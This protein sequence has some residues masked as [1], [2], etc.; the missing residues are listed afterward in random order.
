MRNAIENWC[1]EKGKY[2][3][4][5]MYDFMTLCGLRVG[6]V[7][8]LRFQ[9]VVFEVDED[10]DECAYITVR[11]SKNDKY[12]EVYMPDSL[13]EDYKRFI[14]NLQR[15]KD[16]RRYIFEHH[17][18]PYGDTAIRTL[19]FRI[20]KERNLTH[21]SPHCLRH[22]FAI[23]KIYKGV[24]MNDLQSDMG[25]ASYTTTARYTLPSRENKR[26]SRNV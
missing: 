12:R 25:H 4:L 3:Q 20:C 18:K 16:A 15:R 26:K 14:S 13:L 2:E 1:K 5:F 17:G 21:I 10:G 9:D 7:I 23:R 24:P 6:E 8:K 19:Y 11:E 22:T